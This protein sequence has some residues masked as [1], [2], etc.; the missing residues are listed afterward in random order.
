V[1]I[2]SNYFNERCKAAED[3]TIRVH[4]DIKSDMTF[5]TSKNIK[6]IL[7]DKKIN[8]M[9]QYRLIKRISRKSKIRIFS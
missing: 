5:A 7:M 3:E 1:L 8:N 2:F 6:R 9:I 4:N